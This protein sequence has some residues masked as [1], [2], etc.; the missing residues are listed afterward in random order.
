[1]A[2][3]NLSSV[4]RRL[5]DAPAGRLTA[6]LAAWD[7]PAF[8]D[9]GEDPNFGAAGRFQILT[10]RP[11]VLFV[12]M[13]D[14][15]Q[16]S[17]AGK[18]GI[19]EAGDPLRALGRAAEQYGL[20]GTAAPADP[21]G[22]PF[23]GGLVGFVSYDAGPLVEPCPRRHPRDSRLPDLRFGL[24]DTAVIVDRALG[25]TALW[26]WDLL[27]EGDRALERRVDRWLRA[28]DEGPPRQTPHSPSILTPLH[29]T[30]SRSAYLD[31]VE[32]AIEYIA[33][34]DI[35][36][37][38]LGRRF[39]ARGCFKPLD[40]Y[41][42][43]KES[44]PSPFGAYLAWDDMAVVSASPEWFYQ[45]RGN[46]IVTR[47][48]KGTR[49]RGRDRREDERLAAELA[50]SAKD[51]AE[52]VMIVDLERN[53]LGRV[54]E[55]GSVRVLETSRIESF[56]QV[57]HQVA[58]IEG[59]LRPHVHAVAILRALFP[60]GSI[61]GAPKIR[62]MQIIDELEPCRRGLYTGSIGYLSRGSS[63]WNIAIRTLVIEGDRAHFHVGGGIVADS[64]P[65]QE[66]LETLAKG[67]ALRQ[68][69]D[70]DPAEWS[71]P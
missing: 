58:T 38:N 26:A 65:E 31:S 45:T 66:H 44:S 27:G 63:A 23:Q 49:P 62:A 67:R 40:L 52:L 2:T 14:R 1:V 47:P 39:E 3:R 22:P 53:D 5:L 10:A 33:A 30:I 25:E 50:A 59:R 69:L 6:T 60:G 37:V 11:R 48:I 64:V 32:R 71:D 24:Y 35:F 4:V 36:Q 70:P 57:H 9:G 55:Y 17:A 18:A 8:L 13:G 54:C 43:L 12:A 61:T 42:R 19:W 29:P 28:L 20:G 56:S 41:V 16:I 34:G 21:D 51:R 7:N 15:F 46:R 68:L